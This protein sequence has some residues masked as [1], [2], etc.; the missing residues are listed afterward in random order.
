MA[1]FEI[2]F[3]I[4]DKWEDNNSYYLIYTFSNDNT[5]YLKQEKL[6]DYKPKI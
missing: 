2:E 5:I 3:I 6:N 1:K 4:L